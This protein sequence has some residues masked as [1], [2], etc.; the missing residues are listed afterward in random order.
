M[1]LLHGTW[2]LESN[3]SPG[4]FIW[5]EGETWRGSAQ[6]VHPFQAAHRD[7]L[8]ALFTL[9]DELAEL[10]E[11]PPGP[12]NHTLILPSTKA[13]PLPSPQW[14]GHINLRPNLEKPQ[15]RAWQVTGLMLT[16]AQILEMLPVVPDPEVQTPE[17]LEQE[18][19]LY[20]V[21]LRYWREVTLLAQQL[22]IH[23]QY[24]PALSGDRQISRSR[25]LPVFETNWSQV[26]LY[27]LGASMPGICRALKASG[28]LREPAP[29]SPALLRQVLEL[30]VN[31]GARRVLSRTGCPEGLDPNNPNAINAWLASLHTYN[32]QFRCPA[33]IVALLRE[34]IQG[35][36]KP[37]LTNW[38]ENFA[39]SLRLAPPEDGKR[40]LLELGVQSREDSTVRIRAADLWRPDETTIVATGGQVN[41]V[42]NKLRDGLAIAAHIFPPLARLV[43]SATPSLRYLSTEEAYNFL[44]DAATA[45][46]A[47]G[48]AVQ[49]PNWWK[50]K[51]SKL[52]VSLE[53]RQTEGASQMGLDQVLQY[54]WKLALGGQSLTFEEFQALAAQKVP[55]VNVR[56]QWVNLD[57]NEVEKAIAFWERQQGSGE[58]RAGE[59]LRRSLAQDKGSLGGL[60]IQNFDAQGMLG[61]FL[62]RLKSGDQVELLGAPPGLEGQLRPYQE[63]GVSWLGFLHKWGLGACLA[64]DMGLGKTIEYISHLLW[65]K[66]ENPKKSLKVLLICPTSV[67]SNWSREV[68]KFAP[69]LSVLIQH[70]SN[71][72]KGQEFIKSAS[73]HDLTLTSYALALRDLK[74]LKKV[75]WSGVALDEAQNIKNPDAKQTRAIKQLA[76]GSRVALTGTPVENRLG[77]LWSIMDFLNPGYLGNSERFKEEFALPIERHQSEEA[78]GQLRALVQPFILRRLKTD[79]T[80][81]Q[82]LPE[83]Q[84]SKVYCNLSKEQASLYQAVVQDTMKKLEGAEGIARRGIILATLTKLKQ[85]CNHPAQFLKEG[86]ILAGRSG[87]L[88]R[89]SELI[90]EIVDEAENDKV[91][92]FTQ[93]AE[94]GKMLQKHLKSQFQ[95][96]VP[97]LYGSVSKQKRDEMVNEFQ[98]ETGGPQFFILSIKA[99]GVGLNL[100][101]AN[102]V[103]HFDRWWNPAV[104]NQATDRAFR[105]GQKKNVQ[106]H[107][108]VCV[109]TLEERIDQLIESKKALA[110]QVVGADENWLT[111]LSTDQLRD[112][113]SLSQE[114]LED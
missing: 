114:A 32:D 46:E 69:S 37:V 22:L 60:E 1:L 96:E 93:F 27:R 10:V 82:D 5:A 54:N 92:I 87:K 3:Q 68:Q 84:E 20:G 29:D 78:A 59:F 63:R 106:V 41:A 38:E 12:V 51:S 19:V 95:Q 39:V 45:L 8:L 17:E 89:L 94:M 103:F 112:L 53:V 79:P 76:Q 61:D 88:N 72:L 52:G 105:I 55:L 97:F 80:I 67:I 57:P 48:L 26:A 49:V 71:R 47:Q 111:E 15:L 101:R 31:T 107:K 25:W 81:I 100:T 33:P 4:F 64:D 23:Q 40:W 14:R 16:P 44:R 75:E 90:E 2:L 109:G 11:S 85:V 108:F 110:E 9:A 113:F 34:C 99:G 30:L 62:S 66:K 73:K 91:L 36:L 102:H 28:P 13:G 104:E 77:E 6:E 74:D 35:W 65:L 24:V 50:Q 98:Q 58:M 21:D 18:G 42:R 70:G 56:G 83:K 7:L 86:G 43:R